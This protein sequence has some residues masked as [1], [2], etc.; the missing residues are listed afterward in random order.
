MRYEYAAVGLLLV[1]LPMSGCQSGSGP[2]PTGTFI[3][4]NDSTQILE[5]TLD[6]SLTPNVF[7]RISIETGV[8]KYFGKSVGRYTL[9][10]QSESSS[11]KFIWVKS[12]RDGSLHDV[13]FTADNGKTWTLTVQP[14]GSLVDP[15]GVTWKHQMTRDAA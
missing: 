5:L 7:I 4:Q 10:T 15:G 9:K 6:L 2:L 3:N 1:V 13:W 11:G 14:N 8:N 12:L